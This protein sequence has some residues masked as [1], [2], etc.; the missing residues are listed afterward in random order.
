MT[1]TKSEFG[2][3]GTPGLHRDRPTDSVNRTKWGAA[4]LSKI[5]AVKSV[6]DLQIY[7]CQAIFH[8]TAVFDRRFKCGKVRPLSPSRHPNDSALNMRSERLKFSTQR[9][10]QQNQIWGVE[11]HHNTP[12]Y[13]TTHRKIAIIIKTLKHQSDN[14]RRYKS[15]P[16]Q[17][18]HPPLGY[19]HHYST[20]VSDND[21]T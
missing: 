4:E 2:H 14:R 9:I 18:T 15:T 12:P 17:C 19:H 3:A 6:I 13:Q 1:T 5:Q 10:I 20:V 7:N 16:P 11:Q 21:K 8:S